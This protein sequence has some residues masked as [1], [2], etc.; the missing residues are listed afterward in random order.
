V[1]LGVGFGVLKAQVR[2]KVLLADLDVELSPPP[3]S[4][5]PMCCPASHHADNGLNL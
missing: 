2:P 5:L 3:A 4:Y 1:L